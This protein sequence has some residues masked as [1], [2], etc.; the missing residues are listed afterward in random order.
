M[1]MRNGIPLSTPTERR[2]R[3]EAR[4]AT[5]RE[6]AP[7]LRRAGW[8]LT[9]IGHALGIS[10]A[11]AHQIVKKAER[12]SRDPHWY[13]ALPARAQ[14]LLH[15]RGLVS[16]P[17]IEAARAVAQLSRRELMRM[18]NFGSVACAAIIAWLSRQGLELSEELP[19]PSAADALATADY[20]RA[21]GVPAPSCAMKKS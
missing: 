17:E 14:G 20:S 10:L 7:A 5:L 6:R 3:R 11:R 9:A 12:L 4:S 18:P 21:A 16:L 1:G 8:T 2:I 15:A 13:D 19:K